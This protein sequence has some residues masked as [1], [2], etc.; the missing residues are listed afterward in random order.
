MEW[1]GRAG[2]GGEKHRLED[3]RRG[4]RLRKKDRH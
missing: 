4:E 1:E 3:P 2:E